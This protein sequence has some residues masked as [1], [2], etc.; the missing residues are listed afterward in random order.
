MFPESKM[1]ITSRGYKLPDSLKQMEQQGPW[2]NM[3]MRKL[4]PYSKLSAN[5]TLYWYETISRCIVWKTIV[6]EVEKFHYD[7]KD[8]A[9][10]RLKNKFGPFD[11]N[12]QYC[13]DAPG[14]GYC[15]AY[16]IK[17][18]ERL[19]LPKP[20]ELKFPMIGWLQINSDLSRNWIG[21]II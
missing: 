7:T 8:E 12:Q 11:E 15:L 16:A 18:I 14:S 13:L 21:N 10:L 3:W 6:V 4:W 2:F 19:S 1:F 20:N 17:P 9:F 5:D